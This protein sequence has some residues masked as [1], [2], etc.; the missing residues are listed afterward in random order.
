MT[1]RVPFFLPVEAGNGD[2][3]PPYVQ[4]PVSRSFHVPL[5]LWAELWLFPA[6]PPEL[7]SRRW[8]AKARA[9]GMSRHGEPLLL[10][11]LWL[12]LTGAVG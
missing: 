2:L 12:G 4:P 10:L 9:D 6:G 8:P 5:P 11:Q 3:T 7:L 1:F